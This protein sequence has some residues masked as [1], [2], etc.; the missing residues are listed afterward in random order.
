[1]ILCFDRILILLNIFKS[2]Y[3]FVQVFSLSVSE[4]G[5][6]MSL[7]ARDSCE[8]FH[9]PNKGRRYELLA[10]QNFNWSNLTPLSSGRIKVLMSFFIWFNLSAYCLQTYS[11]IISIYLDT[12]HVVELYVWLAYVVLDCGLSQYNHNCWP[13]SIVAFL[14]FPVLKWMNLD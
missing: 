3:G 2:L 12:N 11:K 8:L 9:D 5:T 13:R 1:M 4:I 7:G 14:L 6:L 10:S